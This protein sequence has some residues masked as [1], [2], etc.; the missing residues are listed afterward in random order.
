MAIVSRYH[1]DRREVVFRASQLLLPVDSRR[2]FEITAHV[3]SPD[4]SR[5]VGICGYREFVRV[6]TKP[7]NDLALV[8]EAVSADHMTQDSY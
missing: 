2:A 7:I 5:F 1:S 3:P 6:I 4:G 8:L